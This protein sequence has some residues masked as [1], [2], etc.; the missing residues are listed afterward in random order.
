[1]VSLF[2]LYRRPSDEK[3][4]LEHY[5]TVHVPLAAKMPGL[6]KL[7]WGRQ[8]LLGNKSEDSLFLVAEMRFSD[9]E[10]MMNGLN[11]PEGRAAAH[12]LEI[13]AKG[14]VTMRMVEWND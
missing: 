10:A 7:N 4:F 9:R 1:M 3:A 2:A 5:R 14:L 6:L 11:S 12:D 8:T 13:L